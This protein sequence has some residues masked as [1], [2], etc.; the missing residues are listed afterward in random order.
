MGANLIILLAYI[1][2]LLVREALLLVWKKASSLVLDL[3]SSMCQTTLG[4]EF[5]KPGAAGNGKWG[6]MVKGNKV[7]VIQ[8]V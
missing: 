5:S 6:G 1:W 7:L 3:Q 4:S 2:I 8:D